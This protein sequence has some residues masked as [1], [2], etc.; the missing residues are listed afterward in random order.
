MGM[1]DLTGMGELIE[2][3]EEQQER[4]RKYRIVVSEIAVFPGSIKEYEI[5]KGYAIDII[6]T[7][8]HDKGIRLTIDEEGKVL[9]RSSGNTIDLVVASN[10]EAIVNAVRTSHYRKPQTEQDYYGLPVRRKKER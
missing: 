7:M 9:I 2:V 1:L 8:R 4:E 6:D 3:T 10:V 5:W